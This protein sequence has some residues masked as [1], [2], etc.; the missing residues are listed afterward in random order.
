MI[1]RYA[2][3]MESNILRTADA[4][5]LVK[6]LKV[7]TFVADRMFNFFGAY[8]RQSNDLDQLLTDSEKALALVNEGK[9]EEAQKVIDGYAHYVRFFNAQIASEEVT[10]FD[11]EAYE[12]K[13]NLATEKQISYIKALL[14]KSGKEADLTNLTKKEASALIESLKA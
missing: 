8:V 2:N 10:Y 1:K 3:G 4:E 12:A 7:E 6:T 14:K 9:I 13:K 11:Y 5:L